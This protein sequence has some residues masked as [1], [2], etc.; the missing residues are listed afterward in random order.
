MPLTVAAPEKGLSSES[1]KLS[2]GSGE[3]EKSFAK[4]EV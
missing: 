3:S 2:K 4:M 1:G